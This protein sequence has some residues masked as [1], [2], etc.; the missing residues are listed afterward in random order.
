[1]LA[2]R[3]LVQS[4]KLLVVLAEILDS[5]VDLAAGQVREVQLNL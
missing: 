5:A 4:L 3:T 1:M 2:L